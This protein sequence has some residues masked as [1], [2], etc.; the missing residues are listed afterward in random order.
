MG[1]E[2]S[3]HVV[4]LY[5][6]VY[7]R[8]LS[9]DYYYVEGAALFIQVDYASVLY[10]YITHWY[11]CVIPTDSDDPTRGGGQDEGVIDYRLVYTHSSN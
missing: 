5:R 1:W 2:D 6:T 9:L 4:L 3:V 7:V 11:L 10:A 8:W